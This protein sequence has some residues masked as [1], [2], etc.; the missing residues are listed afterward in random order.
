[1]GKILRMAKLTTLS[2]LLIVA[3]GIGGILGGIYFISPGIKTAVSKQL[4]GM[5]L[6]STDVNNITNAEK[7]ELPSKEVSTAVA[8]KP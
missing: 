4:G 7:I 6:N 5:E 2:E 1:M 3:V 8:D